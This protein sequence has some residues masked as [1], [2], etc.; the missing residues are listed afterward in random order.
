MYVN[1]ELT[2]TVPGTGSMSTFTIL[3]ESMHEMDT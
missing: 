2:F 3:S 1:C